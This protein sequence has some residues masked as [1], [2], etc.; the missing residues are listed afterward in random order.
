MI[1]SQR[2]LLLSGEFAKLCGVNKKTILYYD[3]IGIFKPTFTGTNGYRYYSYH[4]LPFFYIIKSLL[5]LGM[6]LSEINAYTENKS[7][8]H[9]LH[10]LENKSQEINAKITNLK[11]IQQMI[12]SKIASLKSAEQI[13]SDEIILQNV[14]IEHLIISH[15]IS[16]AFSNTVINKALAEHVAYCND[17]IASPSYIVG[18][19]VDEPFSGRNYY[20]YTKTARAYKALRQYH[21]KPAGQYLTAYLKGNYLQTRPIYKKMFA[22]IKKHRLKT[23]GYFYEESLFDELSSN[24]EQEYLTQIAVRIVE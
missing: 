9:L 12:N 6:S 14:P 2:N 24:V 22:Y 10:I 19:M 16:N 15:P 7:P 21:E 18:S 20:L 5:E 8:A 4:Q 11:N 13:N 1:P 23:S 3:Q 17:H